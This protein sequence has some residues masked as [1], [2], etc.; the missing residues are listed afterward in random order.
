[1]AEATGLSSTTFGATTFFRD[2]LGVGGADP[3][4][5]FSFLL[6]FVLGADGVVAFVALAVVFVDDSFSGL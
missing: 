5:S 1:L 2:D 3:V 6:A 4:S